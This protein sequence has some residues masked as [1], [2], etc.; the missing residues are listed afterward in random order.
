[1]YPYAWK[2]WLK[3][4]SYLWLN[5]EKYQDQGLSYF[6][7]FKYGASLEHKGNFYTNAVLSV[8]V[9]VKEK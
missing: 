8:F 6:L 9:S 1:M 2:V 7:S 5:D 4:I 3:K